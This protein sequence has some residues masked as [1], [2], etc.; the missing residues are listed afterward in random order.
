MI[1]KDYMTEFVEASEELDK[2]C[3][4]FSGVWADCIIVKMG[5]LQMM[6]GEMADEPADCIYSKPH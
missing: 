6:I 1:V 5:E 3:M 2:W 4:R